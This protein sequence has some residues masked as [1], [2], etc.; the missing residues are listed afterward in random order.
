MNKR[1]KITEM[2]QSAFVGR[3]ENLSFLRSLIPIRANEISI[4]LV[5]IYGIGGIGKST[6]IERFNNELTTQKITHAR[7]S[8]RTQTSVYDCLISMYQQLEPVLPF[9]QFKRDLKRHEE[10][11]NRIFSRSDL[12]SPVLRAFVKSSRVALSLVPI[13]GVAAINELISAEDM[14]AQ[15]NKI[16]EIVGRKDGN[17]WIQPEVELTSHFVADIN[18]YCARQRLVILVDEYEHIG[19]LDGWLRDQLFANL[20]CYALLILA[21]RRRLDSPEWAEFNDLIVQVELSPFSEREAREYLHHRNIHNE[22]LI[23]A[24]VDRADGH[25]LVLSLLSDIAMHSSCD[26]LGAI[27]KN[28][29]ITYLLIERLTRNIASE[30]RSALEVCAVLRVIDE[31]RL[32]YML[33]ISD[34]GSLFNSVRIFEFVRIGSDGI[35]LHETVRDILLDELRWRNPIRYDELNLRAITYYE[36]LLAQASGSDLDRTTQEYLYHS[37][38]A[39]E[40]RGLQEFLRIAEEVDNQWM[41]NKLG[42]LLRSMSNFPFDQINSKMWYAY[43]QARLDQMSGRIAA[44]DP[45]YW[46]IAARTDIESLL[47]AYALSNIG[48]ALC[49]A[50]RLGETI[51]SSQAIRVCEESQRL[52]PVND[53]K[54]FVNYSSLASIYRRIGRWE[55]AIMT[56]VEARNMA[57]EH[58]NRYQ[59]ANVSFNLQMLFFDR[60]DWYKGLKAREEGLH[61]VPSETSGIRAALLGVTSAGLIWMGR[62]ADAT[63]D[64]S[65]AIEIEG[66]SNRYSLF[67]AMSISELGLALGM[68]GHF[69]QAHERIQEA[70]VIQAQFSQS[71]GIQRAR[72]LN[73]RGIVQFHQG[74]LAEA[75]VSLEESLSIRRTFNDNFGMPEVILWLG[76][77]YEALL[78]WD[79]AIAAYNSVLKLGVG[80]FYY[81]CCAIIG[82]IRSM[83]AQPDKNN[84]DNKKLRTHI[85]QARI[86]AEKYEYNDCLAY[87]FTVV[88]H[89]NFKLCVDTLSQAYK[90]TVQFYKLAMIYALRYNSLLLDDILVGR[91]PQ[92]ATEPIAR[93]C[94]RRM[95]L[96]QQVLSDLRQWWATGVNTT[97]H[98]SAET[99]TIIPTGISLLHAE[100]IAR[101]L[102]SA[103]Q[104]PYGSV[105]T[106]LDEIL[107]N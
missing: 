96:G 71:L 8:A 55:E 19:S 67:H 47:R 65:E 48:M 28:H 52:L 59:V 107:E 43:Y 82:V 66:R 103:A 41:T 42:D 22:A 75:I 13:P 105:L 6:L 60:T 1:R 84:S 93:Y 94:Q 99:I 39:D 40:S 78:R 62:Y 76:T 20:E 102:E 31:D 72:S 79:D 30:L 14:E 25:P 64:L 45:V 53:P 23:D 5:I 80:R 35:S 63:R 61:Q 58:N 86:I 33:E 74:L 24:M 49:T 44:A 37:L 70:L 85:T 16:Y 50:E 34:V 18:Q 57:I 51:T 98:S 81:E 87:L 106:S 12:P 95:P 27:P 68:Q 90:D 36:R 9:T 100:Q 77:C 38:C 17:Y 11:E 92:L 101:E 88:G 69:L 91:S 89:A 54:R 3:S 73:F 7:L 2:R 10:I 4:D 26:D 21:G 29:E 56:L 46:Q 15:I 104:S 97:E 32:A 83:L